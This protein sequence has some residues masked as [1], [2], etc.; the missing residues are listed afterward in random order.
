MVRRSEGISCEGNPDV[1]RA[2]AELAEVW[3]EAANVRL[4]DVFAADVDGPFFET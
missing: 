3:G 4:G 1:D 2:S